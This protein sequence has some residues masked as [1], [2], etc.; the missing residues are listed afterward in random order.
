[1]VDYLGTGVLPESGKI[2]HQQTAKNIQAAGCS[3]ELRK[4]SDGEIFETDNKN[5]IYHCKF[6]DKDCE[7][8]ANQ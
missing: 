6:K 1:M 4:N 3:V 8:R 7:S 2:V 5:F